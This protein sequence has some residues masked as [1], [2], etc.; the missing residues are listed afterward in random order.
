MADDVG[1][2]RRLLDEAERA[3]SD[4]RMLGDCVVAAFFD[5]EKDGARK[6]RVKA[7]A[8]LVLD[9]TPQ[10][11]LP[12]GR[13][14]AGEEAP[15]ARDGLSAPSPDRE[16]GLGV[17]SE[18]E[19]MARGLRERARPVTPFH[20]EVEF[21]EVFS[22][23]NGGFDAIVGNP[24]FLGGTVIGTRLGIDYHHSLMEFHQLHATRLGNA[25]L[26]AYFLNRCFDSLRNRGCLGLVMTNTVAQGDTRAAGLARVCQ[27][28][29]RI[30]AA[31][32]RLPWPGAAAVIVSVIHVVRGSDM[33]SAILNGKGVSE[34]SP[35][36]F[37]GRAGAEIAPQVS[38]NRRAFRGGEIRGAGFLFE[39]SPQDGSSSLEEMNQ[40]L[41][42]DPSNGE[43]IHAYL[44]GEEFNSRPD[45]SASRY[46]INFRDWPEAKARRWKQP[47]SIVEQRVRPIRAKV[48]QRDRR[49]L[50][51]MHVTRV[52]EVLN[53]LDTDGRVLAVSQ[54]SKHL[55]FGFVGRSTVFSNTLIL[56]LL[57]A[58]SGF[59]V[60][61]SRAH[62]AW[63][64]FVG[65]SMKDDQGTY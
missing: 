33:S 19:G 5:E 13:G 63:S 7:L 45:L 58:N 8:D 25:D 48:E 57:S 36:L 17:R 64:K 2:K 61:Q 28:G 15:E 23:E 10:P 18:L 51:W 14:G 34:I 53:F 27:R 1:E 9:L 38:N 43:V 3:V 44:G 56:L 46:V 11:P 47:F 32:S 65:S 37:P 12:A 35:Y 52:P 16:R 59:A 49:E 24:P 4:A 54:V 26:V 60:V 39:E 42:D 20:W 31:I 29:G 62:E 21:P 6:K 41:R 22:R 40:L 50:W 30:Y 55:A